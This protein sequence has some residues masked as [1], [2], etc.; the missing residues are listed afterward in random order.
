MQFS[1]SRHD[2]SLH[3]DNETGLGFQAFQAIPKTLLT[4]AELGYASAHYTALTSLDFKAIQDSATH[5]NTRLQYHGYTTQVGSRQ[6]SASQ[7]YRSL[8]DS[9]L[10]NSASGHF[11]SSGFVSSLDFVS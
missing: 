2:R 10:H 8:R 6:C 5:T 9:A 7:R 11:A 3:L 4:G 1:A